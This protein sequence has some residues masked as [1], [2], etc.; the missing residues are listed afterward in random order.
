MCRPATRSSSTGA[1]VWSRA[2]ERPSRLMPGTDQHGSLTPGVVLGDR[3]CIEEEIGAGGFGAVYRARQ[4][5]LERQVAIKVMPISG[6]LSDERRLRFQREAAL[7]QRLSHPNTIRLI[8]FGV[9]PE[10]MPFIVMELLLGESLASLLEH[11]G[12]QAEARTARAASD[13][14]KSLMEAHA[15]GGEPTFFGRTGEGRA[16]LL[17]GT[18]LGL[19]R[20]SAAASED[21]SW[22][23][24]RV[25]LSAPRCHG[26][27]GQAWWVTS[28]VAEPRHSHRERHVRRIRPIPR[29]A[30]RESGDRDLRDHRQDDAMAVPDGSRRLPNLD[31]G[32]RC[33]GR[34]RAT[35]L[36]NGSL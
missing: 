32:G 6:M 10:G 8:D 13:V 31:H 16:S 11:E 21:H 36:W 15:L 30:K 22:L 5:S 20:Q 12:A 1:L 4:I 19:E 33:D 14:L 3:Y 35:R 29:P 18:V 34:F 17:H 26:L 27:D 25:S 23:C 7:V 9:T 2:F 28:G 24:A